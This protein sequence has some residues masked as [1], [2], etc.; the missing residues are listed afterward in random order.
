MVLI[1]PYEK[2]IST[3][4]NKNGVTLNIFSGIN[5]NTLTNNT[6]GKS[7]YNRAI[8]LSLFFIT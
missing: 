3:N 6:A 5:R 7:L 1:I 2:Y 4:G 8:N